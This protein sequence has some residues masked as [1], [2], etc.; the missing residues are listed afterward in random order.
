MAA[1]R[2]RHQY[3]GK[4]DGNSTKTADRATVSTLIVSQSHQDP[5]HFGCLVDVTN[6][7]TAMSPMANGFIS[8]SKQDAQSTG[9]EVCREE[10]HGDCQVSEDEISRKGVVLKGKTYR[11]DQR[12]AQAQ[13]T[14]LMSLPAQAG[15]VAP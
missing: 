14:D 2:S 15:G 13:R 12:Y 3:R 10:G 1:A 5:L 4:A 11:A 6:G 7:F 9:T 8:Y